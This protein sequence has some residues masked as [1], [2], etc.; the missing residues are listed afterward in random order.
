MRN[1]AAGGAVL[2]L[3]G[4]L[5]TSPCYAVPCSPTLYTNPQS[6]SGNLLTNPT[7]GT[8]ITWSMIP[9]PDEAAYYSCNPTPQDATTVAGFMKDWFNLSATPAT[10]SFTDNLSGG[11]VGNIGGFGANIFAIHLG[12]GEFAFLY[13]SA[14]SI[15]DFTV[16]TNNISNLR[17]YCSLETCAHTQLDGTPLPA[18][19]WLFGSVVAGGAGFG[20]WRRKRKAAV[21]A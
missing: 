3:L 1:V 18:A 12:Q 16:S 17:T 9:A 15:F 11:S 10:V 19:V 5:A 13:N 7:T 2:A 4:L 6:L 8:N 20:A 21:A 14:I